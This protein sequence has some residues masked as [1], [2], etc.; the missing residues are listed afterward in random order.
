MST[1]RF[2]AALSEHPLATHAA[3]EV[4]GEVLG[5]VGDEPDLAVLFV[6]APH[7]GALEDIAGAVRSV[8]HPGTMLGAAAVSVLGGDR[9]VEEQPAVA[10]WAGRVGPVVPVR[11]TAVPGDPWTIAGL[12]E[13]D[14]APG[15]TLLLLPDPYSFPVELLLESMATDH[16]EVTVIGGLASAARG[17]G[18]N[19]LALDDS[20]VS[21]G[22]VGVVFDAAVATVVS[23]GCRPIGEPMVVT[24]AEGQVLYELAGRPALE[25]FEELA[26]SLPAD[27]LALLRNG[28]H[29]GRVVDERKETF[30]RGD[31]L[32]RNVLGADRDAGAVAVGDVVDIGSTVQFH[33]RD[34]STADED[35][36]SLLDGRPSSGALVFTCNGRGMHLFGQPDHDASVVHDLTGA[37]TAGMFCAGEIGPIG[38]RSFLHG[39]TASVLLFT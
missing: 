37:A 33:V 4:I 16:P 14:L 28:V 9:E 6:T 18:Q 22:A 29:V 19:R 10:L 21:D 32:V 27:E 11:L 35:L 26:R 15:R 24:R 34:A 8:L 5:Q 7:A 23:Q 30:T 20:V 13:R 38:G 39:F 17:P 36:R 3:G 1:T 2:A 25:R 12:P 31:F